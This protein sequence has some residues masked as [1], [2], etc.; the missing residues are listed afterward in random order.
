MKFLLI[1]TLFYSLSVSAD[2]KYACDY[3][4]SKPISF[5][6]KNSKD[7][8]KINLVGQDCLSAPLKV[9]ISTDK[10]VKIYQ[11]TFSY[12][13]PLHEHND[14]DYDKV[15][16]NY[17][18]YLLKNMVSSTSKLPRRISCDETDINCIDGIFPDAENA[19]S[20]PLSSKEYNKIKKLDIPM[21]THSVG[22]ESWSSFIYNKKSGKTIEIYNDTV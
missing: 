12:A 13:A 4:V 14:S 5:R 21:I 1:F 19:S 18:N 10:G 15:V 2:E 6:D 17:L 20:S 11:Y 7:V 3:K 9:S 16:K 22:R 8:L